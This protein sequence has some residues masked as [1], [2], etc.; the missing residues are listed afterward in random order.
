V[1]QTPSYQTQQNYNQYP[2]SATTPSTTHNSSLP[3][4]NN[5]FQP[6]APRPVQQPS[7]SH[8]GHSTNA[9]NPP[10]QIEVYTLPDAASGSIPI[11][12]RSQF[13][14]D[15]AGRVIFYTTPPLDANPVPSDKQSLGHSLRYLADKA[16]NKEEDQK[17]RKA[18]AIQLESEAS[19]RLKRMKY[20][21]EGKKQWILDQKLKELTK[22]CGDLEK[23]TDDLYKQMHGDNWKEM[24]A[25][26]LN[27]LAVLQ[28]EASKRQKEIEAYQK[29]RRQEKDIKITG[30]KWI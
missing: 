30:F 17:K 25:M 29:E 19:D 6:P 12:I 26:D 21:D 24:R 23:G 9:Y 3:H 2:T 20:D 13:H 16:R 11:D 10:R 14:R 1:P 28:E 18:Y 22:W 4:Y 5:H 15:D 7:S 27:R 8:G